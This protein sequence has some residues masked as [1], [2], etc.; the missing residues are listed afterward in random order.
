MHP[1]RIFEPPPSCP[2]NNWQPEDNGRTDQKWADVNKKIERT[3]P[4]GL[5]T[6]LHLEPADIF[7]RKSSP[8]SGSG[9]LLHPKKDGNTPLHLAAPMT[10]TGHRP[11][12]DKCR[13]DVNAK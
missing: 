2:N 11:T 9:H 12:I 10:K 3:R 7:H 1:I 8:A 13:V 6:P 5:F 4:Q